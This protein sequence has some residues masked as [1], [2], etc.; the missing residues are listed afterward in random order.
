MGKYV[1]MLR[2]IGPGNPNMTG[3]KFKGL[4]E[5]L[6]FSGVQTVLASGNVIF[7]SPSSN[8]DSLAELIE[9]ALPQKLGFTRSVVLR[10]QVELQHLI[11]LDPFKGI[12]HDHNKQTYLLVTFFR[13]TPKIPFTLP[14][15]PENKPYTI[16]GKIDDAVYG[17]ID[18]LSAKTPDYMA[19]LEKQFGKDITS[20]TPRT[21][22][23]I[24]SKMS[25]V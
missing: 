18:L 4:F 14:H 20:R 11:D 19:W 5:E 1:A 25:A 23:I 15:T 24:L 7:E 13:Q 8:T 17:S 12:E 9:K 2:G 21:I 16:L 3:E 6:G 10:S 22:R